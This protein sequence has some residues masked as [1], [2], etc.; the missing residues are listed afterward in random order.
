[1][2]LSTTVIRSLQS[3]D[4]EETAEKSNMIHYAPNTINF[5]H[6]P[7]HY[8]NS[9]V[10]GSFIHPC[11][12]ADAPEIDTCTSVTKNNI[13]PTINENELVHPVPRL[14]VPGHSINTVH[15]STSVFTSFAILLLPHYSRETY[16]YLQLF[17]Y[18]NANFS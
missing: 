17:D 4:V 6:L 9:C 10:T 18:R 5:F 11:H 8:F 14:P 16:Y 3:P 15:G 7:G 12:G 2:L 13:A 1:M